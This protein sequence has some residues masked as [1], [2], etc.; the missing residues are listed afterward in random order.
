LPI[1]DEGI[2][3]IAGLPKLESVM[4]GRTEMTDKGLML[5]AKNKSIKSIS[6]S[7]AP[8]VTAEGLKA[9]RRARPDIELR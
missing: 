3:V 1:T 7:S 8:N 2:A 6:F 9:L 4:L 5:L